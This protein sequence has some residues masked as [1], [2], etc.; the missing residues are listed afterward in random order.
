MTRQHIIS[1]NSKNKFASGC[2]KTLWNSFLSK[3][4]F[5]IREQ[6]DRRFLDWKTFAA[7]LKQNNLCCVCPCNDTYVS[8]LEFCASA[9]ALFSVLTLCFIFLLSLYYGYF[10]SV[11]SSLIELLLPSFFEMSF[12]SNVGLL[13]FIWSC[14]FT[15]FFFTFFV[16][17]FKFGWPLCYKSIIVKQ[18]T[19][20]DF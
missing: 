11:C 2:W 16:L 19:F 15:V 8:S 17:L 14:W 9:L 6:D 7:V 4:S 3:R 1:C 20:L 10:L 5:R 13:F 18:Q 12:P